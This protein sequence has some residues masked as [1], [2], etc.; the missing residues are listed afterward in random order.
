[1]KDWEKLINKSAKVNINNKNFDAIFIGDKE[2]LY[3]KVNMTGDI[4]EWRNCNKDLDFINAILEEDKSKLALINCFNS[5]HNSSGSKND[6]RYETVYWIDRIAKNYSLTKISDK[7]A[8]NIIIEFDDLKWF[9]KNKVY[10]YDFTNNKIDFNPFFNK[11]VL[12]NKSVEFGVESKFSETFYDL[13]VN[14]KYCFIIKFYRKASLNV[15]IKYVYMIKNLLMILGKRDVNIINKKIFIKKDFSYN[16]IFDCNYE[17]EK[18]NISE[19]SERIDRRYG[20]KYENISDF[21]IVLNG[22][23]K[24]YNRL[25]PLLEI[26]YN[27]VKNKV[28]TLTRLVNDFAMLEYYSR[29]F[30]SVAS[31]AITNAKRKIKGEKPKQE[32]DFCDMVQSL[33]ENINIVF[34]LSKTQI[35][36]ISKKI[37][38]IRTY[39][40]H[41]V[42]KS[43]KLDCSIMF[44]Y[45]Y[46]IE[47]II[48]LNIYKLIGIEID[49]IENI[50]FNKYYYNVKAMNKKI[51]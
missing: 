33:L 31:L 7:I 36:K 47:D 49:K 6:R 46:F 28:P 50:S 2:G 32:A 1:M 20:L 10:E 44:R 35:K 43:Q 21:G 13:K 11:Y 17:N 22:F 40:I 24:E 3:I 16:N 19:I 4:D 9:V 48:L 27:I 41:Y 18:S 12:K 25:N 15:I 51:N 45:V 29:E 30:D 8:D 42:N 26:Y 37:K 23:E 34:N 39:Y 14:S 38:D 5:S